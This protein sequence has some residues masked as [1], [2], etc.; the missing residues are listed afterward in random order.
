MMKRCVNCGTPFDTRWRGP[1][2]KA[3]SPECSRERE[4]NHAKER[5][6]T[7]VDTFRV[8]SKKWRLENLE[9]ARALAKQW[10]LENSERCSARVKR[11][12]QKNRQRHRANCKRW[13]QENRERHNA[14][15]RRWQFEN[16]ERYRAICQKSALKSRE[17]AAIAIEAIEQINPNALKGVGDK[18]TAALQIFK[19]FETQIPK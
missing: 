4:S 2:A 15:V 17:R 11:W 9:R 6:K 13:Q 10:R 14:N 1:R 3:C 19:H 8:R 12:Q 5:Y 7:N 18:R 16:P